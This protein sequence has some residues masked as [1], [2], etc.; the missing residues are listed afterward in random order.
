[1]T[2]IPNN[3]N[4]DLV[5][6][7]VISFINYKGGVGKTTTTFHIG[8]ALALFHSKRVL[9]IDVDPQTNLTFLCAI[10]ERWEK[11][12][13]DNGSVAGLF[14]A[15][16][17]DTLDKFDFG[18][19]IWKFPIRIGTNEVIANLELIPS[20]VELLGVDIDLA[21]KTTRKNETGFYHEQLNVLRR[22]IS[23]IKSEFG[24]DTSR[25][26]RDALFYIEQRS[27]LGKVIDTVK[28]KYDYILI[29]CPPNLYL[30]TQNALAASDYYII[31]TIPDH[32]SSIG[33]STLMKKITDLNNVLIEKYRV[34]GVKVKCVMLKGILFTMVRI[35]GQNVVSTYKDRMKDL[36]EKYAGLYFENYISW[37]TGYTEAA[38]QAV[39]VFSLN[40][41]N[42]MRVAE[43]YKEVAKEFLQKVDGD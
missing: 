10:P 15:Y 8:C 41:E 32:L 37:G 33:I 16:L 26:V 12:K 38:A 3:V 34:I 29:D 6:G 24:I 39:P 20:D 1:M 36:Q 11:F 40:E 22:T 18:K 17:N 7:K 31:T 35:F 5:M 23:K 14:Q 43:Q 4:E 13:K 19:I 27:I 42:A 21:A 28:N 25:N 30:V 9:L 2:S